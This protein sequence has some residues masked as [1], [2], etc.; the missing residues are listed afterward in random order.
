MS[1]SKL[2]PFALFD[3]LAGAFAN[4]VAVFVRGWTA[5]R[6]RRV[7][8]EMLAFDDHM[9]ADI[10]LRRGDVTAALAMPTLSDPSTRLRILAVERRAG[11]RAMRREA[12]AGFRAEA[13]E[14]SN[15]ATVAEAG[16]PA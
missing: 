13:E 10:G 5:H 4:G 11:S 7:V 3:T 9:L 15:R 12:V 2:T 8:R 14:G 1:H 6:H 16:S